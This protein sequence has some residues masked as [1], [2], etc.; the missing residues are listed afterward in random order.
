MT[1]PN[2][3]DAAIEAAEQRIADMYASGAKIV[4]GDRTL[5][6]WVAAT[7]VRAAAPILIAAGRELGYVDGH[8]DGYI[9]GR[10]LEAKALAPYIKRLEDAV[11]RR[12]DA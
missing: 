12:G 3:I 11:G 10:D 6:P 7:A 1:A 2:P 5:R 4:T 8:A 9:D